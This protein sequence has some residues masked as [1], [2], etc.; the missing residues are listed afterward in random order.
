MRSE[1]QTVLSPCA[2]TLNV[3]QRTTCPGEA[4][5]LMNKR[6]SRTKKTSRLPYVR[7]KKANFLI[8]YVQFPI[9]NGE[10]WV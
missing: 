2:A 9:D 10:D 4:L 5:G 3:G 6:G 1:K 8:I 7:L